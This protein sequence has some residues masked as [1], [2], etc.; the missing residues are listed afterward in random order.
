MIKFFR[1]HFVRRLWFFPVIAL[2]TYIVLSPFLETKKLADFVAGVEASLLVPAFILSIFIF[3]SPTEVEFCKCY[4]FSLNRLCL[5]QVGPYVLFT[6]L[7]MGGAIILFPL[8]LVGVTPFER[9]LIFYTGA[10]NVLLTVSAA[11]FVR[12][13]I[14]NLFGAL[15]FELVFYYLLTMRTYNPDNDPVGVYYT[16]TEALSTKMVRK[17]PMSMFYTNRLIVLGVAVIL[18]TG[19]F[20]LMKNKTYTEAES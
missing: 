20:F 10:T 1:Y 17:L 9:L 2:W 12:V 6:L 11:V 14:R 15:G 4:G 19:A 3:T 7:T 8:E 18:M 13:L 5:A 16:I